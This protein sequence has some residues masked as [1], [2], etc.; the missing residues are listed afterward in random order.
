MKN[1][2][3]L[4]C[5]IIGAIV[6]TAPVQIFGREVGISMSES[7]IVKGETRGEG[8]LFEIKNSDYLN[9]ALSSDV[10][11]RAYLKSI[12]KA[13]DLDVAAA[14]S[15]DS[16]GITIKGLEPGKIYYKYEDSYKNK[17]VF[18]SSDSGSYFWSQGLSVP[19]HVWFKEAQE[20]APENLKSFFPSTRDSLIQESASQEYGP[21][22]L[23]DQC[24]SF[25]SLSGDGSTC[26]LNQDINF[27]VEITSDNF[28]LDCDGHTI[29]GDE[30]SFCGVDLY[31]RKNIEIK[32][33]EI[34]GVGYG[35]DIY[36]SSSV[37]IENNT[38]SNNSYGI[39][40]AY[41]SEVVFE[42][43]R[44]TGDASTTGINSYVSHH[45]TYRENNIGKN[46][47]AGINLCESDDNILSDNIIAG[48]LYGIDV[49]NS[50]NN[51]INNNHISGSSFCGLDLFLES[52]NNFLSGNTV[53]DSLYGLDIYQSRYN[54]VY[55][56]NI[57]NNFYQINIYDSVDNFFDNGYPSGGNYWS[58]YNGADVKSGP[59]QD[60]NGSDGIGDAAYIFDGG[61][62][63]YPFIK[64]DGWK[65]PKR[66][67][68]LIV[69]GITGTE[70]KKGEELLWL[71]LKRVIGDFTDSFMDSLS[72]NQNVMPTDSTV[73]ATDV[74]SKKTFLNVTFDYTDGL[75]NEFASQ[76]YVEN[77]SVFT[78]PYDWRYGVS[79]KYADGKTNSDLLKQKIDSILAQ[80][81]ADKVDVVAHSMG[82]LIVKK[83][84]QDNPAS[85]NIGKA[86]FVGVPNTGAPQAIKALLQ[87]DN[88]GISFGPFGLSDS[89]MKKIAENMPGVYDLLPS[90][91]YYDTAGSFVSKVDYPGAF[92]EPTE[93]DLSYQG[94]GSYLIQE[95]GF[96]SQAF[97]NA[98]SLHTQGFDGY[99]LRQS[100]INFY[101]ID[102]CKTATMANF[103][104]V[105][106]KDIFGNSH[107]SFGRVD[108]K[109]GDGTVPV[110]SSTNL[111]IDQNNK[112]Y[113][114]AG[115][116]SKLLSQDGTR[117]EI[118]NLISGS[119][120]SVNQNV[121]TQDS[122]KCQLNGK[123][124]IVFS[125]V[126]VSVTD[127]SG[128]KLGL[129]DGNII[130]QIPNASFQMMGEHKFIYLPQDGGQVY[131]IN[132]QGTGSGIY[133]IKSQSIANGET[134]KTEIFS[135]LPVTG[136]LT[137]QIN[138]NPQDN[139]TT[140]AIQQNP[141]AGVQT[142]LPSSV[143]TDNEQED[144]FSPVSAAVL[145]GSSGQQNFYRSDVLVN[146]KATDNSSGVL[147]ISYNLEG[148]GYKSI[149]GDTAEVLVKD[150][151]K[152]ELLF[153][154]TDKAG[155]NELEKSIVFTID[156]TAPEVVVEFDVASKDLKF[157]GKDT[158]PVVVSDKDDKI[159]L[160]DSAG[161]STELVLKDKNRKKLMKAEIKSLKYNGVAADI[162][163]NLMV[164]AWLYDK[165]GKLSMLSQYVKAKKGYNVLAVY[166][167][168]STS[169]VG[170]DASGVI[171]KNVSGLK[172]IKI[173]TNKGD[174]NWSY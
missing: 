164:F 92:S 111:P 64:Q 43:N 66:S 168:K 19:H 163:K 148:K 5:L 165:K 2:F 118:V 146:M 74:L 173:T 26:V 126:D 145:S 90:Q 133:T 7:Q 77:E 134:T 94:F 50:S 108:F 42:K 75:I 76:G 8:F 57:V 114:L 104:E 65:E 174:L 135:N 46:N 100:G 29:A 158:N 99:D 93:T 68:V 61:Q 23:P 147:N 143:L 110:Q 20:V 116:H 18:V 81:G 113:V 70:M 162:S 91:R 32:N 82:G 11:I 106:Y 49:Y 25:G 149:L 120:L 154:S 107:T 13:I 69:P 87:G 62:D 119:N 56:N 52:N 35:I 51:K 132:L 85:R 136:Q 123:A 159:T 54:R 137:G 169:F 53:R 40:I 36:S 14:S 31:E 72:F 67:P 131:N 150:E 95:K 45:N 103:V 16:A 3:S 86:V 160:A 153:F 27:G 33:C 139:S 101:A 34:V 9:V 128:N 58:D 4:W 10:K 144:L 17:A 97:T 167:G 171:L 121:V 157:S 24:S 102:G 73:S 112:Y 96:N 122:S 48:S 28:V 138:I 12:S 59:N 124:I 47:F 129:A 152:H 39:S 155:N 89:E 109:I 166:N 41:S 15:N 6:L 22:F 172:I 98:Q 170:K 161:N 88:F 1:K 117:Q 105:N 130:N 79:G 151:G 142:I 80:T 140:L 37:R 71:D 63:K 38:I 83:Y 55:N 141:G 60:R 125:P 30:S 78:F 21:I 156:K 127:Q 115:Q 84:V 44:I